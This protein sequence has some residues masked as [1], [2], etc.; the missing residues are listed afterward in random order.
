M[1]LTE[2]IENRE[3]F[4]KFGIREWREKCLVLS[5]NEI[6]LIK[7]NLNS[8]LESPLVCLVK[9]PFP[10]FIQVYLSRYEGSKKFLNK[11]GYEFF[12]KFYLLPYKSMRLLSEKIKHPEKKYDDI[13]SSS[14]FY[15]GVRKDMSP[16]LEESILY[17]SKNASNFLGINTKNTDIKF[18]Y[19]TQYITHEE[20]V[21][22]GLPISLYHESEDIDG[23][24]LERKLS[25]LNSGLRYIIVNYLGLYGYDRKS[26]RTLA[27]ILGIDIE[28]VKRCLE[29]I[30]PLLSKTYNE[31]RV[32]LGI[33]NPESDTFELIEYTNS[34]FNKYNLYIQTVYLLRFFADEKAKDLISNVKLEF[35]MRHLCNKYNE[36]EKSVS[37]NENEILK[38]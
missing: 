35:P 12:Y 8:N 24:D 6:H 2:E 31:Y 1:K 19:L 20:A 3:M 26:V 29:M 38:K 5:D 9:L 33:I 17:L 10:Q 37:L 34:V 28:K 11:Y 14:S 25:C 22:L 23:Y 18:L 16:E 32:K 4:L 15:K 27:K 21:K 36:L 13:I 7:D 30:I